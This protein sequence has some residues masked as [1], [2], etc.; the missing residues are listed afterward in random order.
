MNR[1]VTRRDILKTA[2]AAGSS[3]AFPASLR[4]ET[5]EGEDR[6]KIGACDWS[7]GRRGRPD[8]LELAKRIGLD[9]VQVTFGRPG[10]EHDL[11]KG[12]VRREYL[13]AVETHGVQIASLAM[14]M[15][16]QVPYS[17]DPDA[18]QWV[19]ECVE[20]MPKL[21]QKVALLAFFSK[22]DIK[23]KPDLQ[24]AVIR[25]LKRVAPEIGRASCRERV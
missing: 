24:D 20:V 2:A 18:E 3:L 13:R 10:D 11:R 4:S 21:G 1:P 5:G 14:G 22:G 16:N 19:R 8:A 25:R 6:F 23:G 9:G 12:E 7:I 17:S 15:L